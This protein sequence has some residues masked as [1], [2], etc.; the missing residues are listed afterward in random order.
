MVIT[1]VVTGRVFPTPYNCYL[2]M[3]NPSSFI[4]F[5]VLHRI[6]FMIAMNQGYNNKFFMD[7]RRDF[8]TM[9][10]AIH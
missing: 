10:K 5:A 1:E 2:C 6:C 8:G 7:L 3:S 4:T 9:I